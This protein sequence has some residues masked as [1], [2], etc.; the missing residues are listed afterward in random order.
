LLRRQH[1]AKIACVATLALVS[2]AIA[3]KIAEKYHEK[4]NGLIFLRQNHGL[5]QNLSPSVATTACWRCDNV[6]KHCVTIASKKSLM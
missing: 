4:F 5:H 1:A 3:E 6:Q 2:D